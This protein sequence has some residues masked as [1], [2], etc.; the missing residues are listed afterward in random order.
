MSLGAGMK[1]PD[2]DFF[3]PAAGLSDV[4]SR[5]HPHERFQAN[6]YRALRAFPLK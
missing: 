5:L 3:L 6:T 1:S 2:A 4:E